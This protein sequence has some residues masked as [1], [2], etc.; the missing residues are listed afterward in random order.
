MAY[1]SSTSI[2]ANQ[3]LIDAIASFAAAVGWTVE[4]NTLVGAN[5]TVTLRKPGVTDYIHIFNT[6]TGNV[7]MRASVGYDAGLA[8]SAQPNVSP[9]DTIINALTGPYPVVWFFADGDCVHVVVRRSDI[10]GAYAHI[11]FGALTK[12]G[13]YAGGTYVDGT[14]FGTSGGGT[15]AWGGD[16]HA[17]FG[18]GYTVTRG[19]LR[20]DADGVSN[21]WFPTSASDAG[22]TQ[23]HADGGVGP[24][25]SVNMYSGGQ[26]Y[27]T[28]DITRLVYYADN[29]TFSGRSFLQLIQINVPRAG[30]PQYV[31]PAGFVGNLRYVSLAKFDPEQEL[32][33][34]GETWMVFPVARK[35]AGSSTSGAPIGTGIFGF[36]IRKVT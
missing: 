30:S 13:A 36:A 28:Y 2:A 14:Y 22:T 7:R 1:Q 10:T 12:Y 35:A 16:D 24:E 26:G 9:A 21:R 3:N 32:S 34:A 23:T 31:S 27:S 8:P 33:I 29:N 25:G 15:G 6:D 4:R 17:P 18:L 19:Y 5:R 11:M 20:C